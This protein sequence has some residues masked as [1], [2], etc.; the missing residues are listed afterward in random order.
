MSEARLRFLMSEA[1]LPAERGTP[2]SRARPIEC[3]HLELLGAVC[4]FFEPFYGG[5]HRE[6]LTHRRRR[7]LV[8]GG[9][10]GGPG[11]RP[12][13]S[14]RPALCIKEDTKHST[15]NTHPRWPGHGL[16]PMVVT[17]KH[18]TLN[19]KHY[20]NSR[21]ESNKAEG[22]GLGAGGAPGG[23]GLRPAGS[24]RPALCVLV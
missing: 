24:G 8:G 22:E 21:L 17:P 13:G 18:S 4:A 10:P 23:P 5:M 1:R 16:D 3:Y 2:A 9:G 15:P 19:T 20:L 7:R 14:G 12:A 6:R 11:S